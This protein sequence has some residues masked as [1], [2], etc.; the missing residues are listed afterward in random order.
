MKKERLLEEVIGI[1]FLALATL[2]FLSLLSYTPQ[3]LPWHTTDPN[4]SVR[5]IINVFG[6]YLSG[7]LYFVF[8]HAS[9]L[10]P[11]ILFIFSIKW[12]KRMDVSIGV[13]RIIGLVIA[14]LAFSSFFA[15]IVAEDNAIRFLR[16]GIIGLVFSDFLINYFGK[17]GAYVIIASLGLLSLPLVAEISITPLFS[18]FRQFSLVITNLITKIGKVKF[19]KI[20]LSRFQE[21]AKLSI[22]KPHIPQPQFKPKPSQPLIK[23]EKKIP[24]PKIEISNVTTKPKIQIAKPEQK[25]QEKPSIKEPI[26]QI[27]DENY[28]L[29]SLDLLNSP[30][31]LSMRQIKD[32]LEA[33]IH[34][35]EDTLSDFGINVRVSNVER[36]PVITRYELEPAPGVKIQKIVTLSDDISLALKATSVRIVAPIPGK[37]AVGIEVPNSHSSI[38][39]LT[40]VLGSQEFQKKKSK[41]SL[42]LGKDIVGKPIIADLG[43]M[44]HLL[45]AGTTGSGKTVCVNSIITSM[46]FN[47]TP[48]E[49]K[50]LMV[51]PK[52]VELAPFNGLPHLLCPVVTESKKVSSALNWVVKEM[53]E[54]YQLLAKEGVRNIEYYNQ[55]N[56]RLPYIVV[57]V[58]E[59]ADLMAVAQNQIEEAITRLAQLS[60]AVGIHLILATQRPSVDVITG[61]IKANFPA[62]ISF[63]VASKVDSRT[64]LDMNGADKLLG[65]GDM[66]FLKPGES[67]LIRVQGSYLQ[68]NEIEKVTEFICNQAEP[69]YDEEIIKTQE[70]SEVIGNFEKDELFDTAVKLILESQHASVS[71][72][73]RRL[74]LGYTRAARLIDMMESEGIIGPFRGSKPREILVDKDSFLKEDKEGI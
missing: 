16:G 12:F 60:R 5:N 58:D 23:D 39:Y 15:I 22:R 54:R 56:Q 55:K 73:Q 57:I 7:I 59:L 8:G 46:L 48:S 29:P 31:P 6:A 44:P 52:M 62:R 66:L 24:E 72:L 47:V 70:K 38:V 53:N 71:I 20:T 19:L 25:P 40:E 41:L 34:I 32:D 28:V 1:I 11:L 64:V 21:R 35:L 27:D 17:I 9:Y 10:I 68:D 61:V 65:R 4:V 14:F 69:I 67:K 33:N 74:R 63:K 51:D 3:D 49:I 13:S 50:F 37:S 30:P 2:V 36:G 43:E 45:I 18:L 42:A 26:R